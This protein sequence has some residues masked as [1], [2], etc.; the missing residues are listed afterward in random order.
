MAKD[1]PEPLHTFKQME[2]RLK[3]FARLHEPRRTLVY[4]PGY[5]EHGIDSRAPSYRP[6]PLLGGERAFGNL[7]N[8]AHRMGYRV[9][10]HTNVLALAFDHPAFPSF[11]EH[12]VVDVFGRPQG[13]G[14]D[15]DGDWLPEPYFAYVNPGVT[16][17]GDLM[18]GVL[19]ELIEGFS[20]DAVFLDQTLLAFNVSRGPNFLTGMR[21]HIQRLQH[22]FP[23]VLFAGEGFH[24]TVARVLPMAQIHGIDSITEV[25]GMEGKTVWRTAHPVSTYLFGRYTR[26]T[27]HLLTKHPDHPMFAMQ[28]DAYG[29]LGVLPALCLSSAEQKIDVPAVRRMIRR[30]RTL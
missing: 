21:D 12:Q 2:S 13:W 14:L 28:E 30:A 20:L 4:L 7:V 26:F 5:A 25:H 29:R 8:L 23:D 3:Q 11:R 1:R 10:I 24:E 27:A 9:M 22:A 17:W 16:A 6:S 15:M 19:R 18:E